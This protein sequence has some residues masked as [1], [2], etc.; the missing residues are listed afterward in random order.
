MRE[1]NQALGVEPIPF[2]TD[3]IPQNIVSWLGLN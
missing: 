1:I 2:E 3:K